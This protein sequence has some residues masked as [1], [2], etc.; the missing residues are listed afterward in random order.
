MT[1]AGAHF[2]SFS[3]VPGQELLEAQELAMHP[4]IGQ[5]IDQKS[6]CDTLST[7][8][9]SPKVHLQA[10]HLHPGAAGQTADNL[11]PVLLFITD[12]GTQGTPLRW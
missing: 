5:T 7:E 4:Q 3:L 2:P 1:K 10:V 12:G 6:A 11:L 8:E 9:R